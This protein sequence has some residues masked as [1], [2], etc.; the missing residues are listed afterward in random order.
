MPLNDGNIDYSRLTRKDFRLEMLLGL[1]QTA[2]VYLAKAPNGVNVALKIPRREVRENPQMR[3]RFAQEVSLSISLVHPHLVRGL[4]GRPTGDGAFLALEYFP[5]GSLEDRISKTP[6]A[7]PD[8]VRGLQQIGQVVLFL[9]QR[10]IIH[11][12]I[13]PS[14]IY[15]KGAD[16]KL[17]DLGVAKSRS[18]PRPLERAGSPF[19]MAPELF[20][21]EEATEASDTYS[22]GVL[23][24][25]LL[26]GKRPFRA[27]T[28]DDVTHAHLHLAP[29]PTS[30]P[31]RLDQ[32]LR[33]L[34]SKD[35]KQRWS[36]PQF[37]QVLASPDQP[38]PAQPEEKEKPKGLRALFRRRS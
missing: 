4:A 23:A 33:N 12:D 24:Y 22:F 15:L 37:L 30:L 2:Q 18:N 25:E 7:F 27:E 19:Y 20:A 3:E 36:I 9:H 16:F 35:P 5:E 34:L 8:A 32:A 13:K 21:G 28:L 14:N 11:Q 10:G 1:G 38:P 26:T 17:G 6:L 31:R 29:P